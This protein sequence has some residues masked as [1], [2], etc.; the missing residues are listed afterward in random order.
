VR[1]EQMRVK[2]EN[3]IAVGTAGSQRHS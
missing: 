1:R 3:R 2:A